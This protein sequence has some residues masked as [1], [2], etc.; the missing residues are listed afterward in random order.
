MVVTTG[1]D[2]RSY[3]E[4]AQ[5]VQRRASRTK[6]EQIEDQPEETFPDAAANTRE[7]QVPTWLGLGRDIRIFEIDERMETIK[8][9]DHG[10]EVTLP[11]GERILFATT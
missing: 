7:Q 9:R 10:Y 11:E 4:I 3:D 6:L 2:P 1:G 5:A 8:P